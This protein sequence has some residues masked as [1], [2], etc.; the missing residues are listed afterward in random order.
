MWK[1]NCTGH[2]LMS[3]LN[4]YIKTL[5]VQEVDDARKY[6]APHVV[7][8]MSVLLG[9]SNQLLTVHDLANKNI[10]GTNNF[11]TLSA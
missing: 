4:I 3:M 2:N 7:Q 5:P 8:V 1:M 6:P 11:L 9:Q 10:K